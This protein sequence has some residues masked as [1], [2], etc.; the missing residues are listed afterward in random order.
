MREK[1]IAVEKKETDNPDP[2]R[3]PTDQTAADHLQLISHRVIRGAYET[4]LLIDPVSG[5]ARTLHPGNDFEAPS[6]SE[7]FNYKEMVSAYIIRN[8][9][10]PNP[11][12]IMRQFSLASVTMLLRVQSVCFVHFYVSGA[13]RE[14]LHKKASF[15]YTDDARNSICL[16]IQDT[17]Q[18][19]ADERSRYLELQKALDETR[20]AAE[21]NN[22]FLQLFNRD[23]RT[24]IH[25]ILGLVE[26]ADTEVANPDVIRDYLY[27]IKS[28]GSSMSEIID[29][30][31]L[32]SRMT[33]APPKPQPELV[34]LSRMFELL[35]SSLEEKLRYRGLTYH[36]E[37]PEDLSDPLIADEHYLTILLSKLLEFAMNNTIRG[38]DIQLSVRE[39]L[40]KQQKTLIEFTVHSHGIDIHP[41]QIKNLFRPNDYLINEL[42]NDLSS[43][44]LSL[45]I[46]KYYVSV[47]GGSI[48]AES[49][50]D[51]DTR[52]TVSLNFSLPAMAIAPAKE[53]SALSIPDLRHY[54]A[55]IVDDD[56]IN[57]EVGT[58]LLARTGI[59]TI[60]CTNGQEA[61]QTVTDNGGELDVL[62]IDIRMPGMDGLEVAR[63]VRQMRLP[64]VKKV[65][66]IAMTVNDSDADLKKSLDAGINAHLIKPIDPADLYAVLRKYLVP[67]KN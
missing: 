41:E 51:T 44:D 19:F 57:L 34:S 47:L 3:I 25:S 6:F 1:K 16:L 24:P 17:T 52:I 26:I 58:K 37:L 42:R 56:P 22:Q 61:L 15:F 9:Y 54:R 35:Q 67:A 38:G 23:M 7:E 13:K 49:G 4:I 60:S 39:L 59:R 48:V 20:A 36:Y 11:Q 28:A 65:P 45:V 18:S 27:K 66:I 30:I 50:A 29:D 53:P 64:F 55:L 62:L 8:C 40:Q 21:A 32:L 12:E 10:E 63:R 46:L 43:I 33:Q 31:L 14:I 2:D 5:T